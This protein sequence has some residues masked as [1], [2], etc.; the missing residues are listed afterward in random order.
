MGFDKRINC[1]S[2]FLEA[3]STSSQSIPAKKIWVFYG[4]GSLYP[5]VALVYPT[6]E[7]L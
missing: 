6:G 7:N 5:S 2:T 3:T 1:L 4:E